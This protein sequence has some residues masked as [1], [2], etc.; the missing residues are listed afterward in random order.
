MVFSSGS[1]PFGLLRATLG[2]LSELGVVG[3][4][5]QTHTGAGASM[6]FPNKPNPHRAYNV[7]SWR[8]PRVS[9]QTSIDYD[10]DK[11]LLR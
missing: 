3:D 11:S 5:T 10:G 8:Y 6:A 4:H 2:W 9:T 1:D 7:S